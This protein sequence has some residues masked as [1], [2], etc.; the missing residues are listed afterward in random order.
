MTFPSAIP[1]RERHCVFRIAYLHR[2][3]RDTKYAI[4]NIVS[5]R[6]RI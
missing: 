6:N 2:L 5:L 4:R 1:D 3:Y